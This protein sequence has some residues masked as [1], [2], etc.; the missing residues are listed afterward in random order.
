MELERT[1][2]HVYHDRTRWP[3]GFFFLL[4]GVELDG[5][6]VRNRKLGN[7][8]TLSVSRGYHLERG[9][10]RAPELGTRLVSFNYQ[11]EW[12]QCIAFRMLDGIKRSELWNFLEE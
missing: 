1:Y 3:D 4:D 2:Q 5:W 12:T 8:T 9:D 6:P 11:G 7:N 10:V